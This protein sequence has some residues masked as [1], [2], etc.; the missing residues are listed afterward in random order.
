[1]SND[2]NNNNQQYAKTASVSKPEHH[3]T[4]R[5]RTTDYLITTTFQNGSESLVRRTVEDFEFLRRRLVDVERSG[6]IVPVL[7]DN[8]T[9]NKKELFTDEFVAMRQD[10]LNRFLQ[11]TVNHPDLLDAPS[12]FP[13]FTASPTEWKEIVSKGAVD[14]AA[15]NGGDNPTSE[16]SN[17]ASTGSA[18]GL[19]SRAD[20]QPEDG[21]VDDPN[22]IHIDA[23]AAMHAGN[24]AAS[25]VKKGPLRRW[26]AAKREAVALQNKDLA[27]EETPAET[28]YFTN[29]QNYA[30][31]METCVR[32][33][34][35][36]YKDI[37]VAHE[38]TASK[39][40]TMAAAF[41]NMW[42]ETELSTT[43]S[44]S[45][46]Q[47]IGNV[48]GKVSK[49]IK[50][51]LPKNKKHLDSPLEDLLLDVEALKA[52]LMKRKAAAF[53][54][55][56]K[57][58]E[59]KALNDQISKLR[60]A[61]D[62][63]AQQDKYYALEGAIRRSD[64]EIEESKKRSE[65]ISRRLRRDVDRFRI[66]FHERMRQV[67]ETFHKQQ[68]EYLQKEAMVW[69]SALPSLTALDTKRSDLPTA[70]KGI[71]ASTI[72]LS[73][74]TGGAKAVVESVSKDKNGEGLLLEVT[75]S[76][77]TDQNDLLDLAAAPPASAPPPPP[78]SPP[79]TRESTGSFDS[80][81]L[82]VPVP[83]PTDDDV[84]ENDDDTGMAMGGKA[85]ASTS[86][87]PVMKSV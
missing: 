29:L 71:A 42:G 26:W 85:E 57:T 74:S 46:Y 15:A 6:I 63:S 7:P 55:T 60:N 41:S 14:A 47:E 20:G 31:H 30:E 22:S 13:F 56:K 32:I 37:V 82:D 77:A 86:S 35:V 33:L 69:E 36:D 28:K 66:E 59:N 68:I 43:S 72:N 83:T 61:R 1:M 3:G 9:V 80:I 65:L 62:F 11:R 21:A 44:S 27:L 12:L 10:Q 78:T 73:Y 75:S 24:P 76:P 58:Q 2:N 16:L 23:D 49:R 45:M 39:Y 51:H 5:S 50:E 17:G 40:E 79:A 52:A 67:L 70:P 87:R 38:T 48:W 4:G 81:G 64:L 54:F 25:P 19:R 34:S 8:R 84:E 18:V 53:D